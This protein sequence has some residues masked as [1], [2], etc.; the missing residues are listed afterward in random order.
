MPEWKA[1]EAID[2]YLRASNKK[3][4]EFLF[5]GRRGQKLPMDAAACPAGF[6]PMD[7]QHWA[8]P[9]LL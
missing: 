6:L 3:P 9:E 4:G 1:R 8:E 2:N 7:R 5:A